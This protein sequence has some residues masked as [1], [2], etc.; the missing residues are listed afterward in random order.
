M[1]VAT[2]GRTIA[3]NMHRRAL[4]SAGTGA[5][6]SRHRGEGCP[7][8][9]GRGIQEKEVTIA[10]VLRDQAGYDT[11]LIGKWHLGHG[12]PSLLPLNHGFDTFIGHT[13]GCID[14]FTMTYGII[15][16]WYNGSQHVSENGSR[17]IDRYW[18]GRVFA[19]AAHTRTRTK[20][21]PRAGGWDD[22]GGQT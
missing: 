6:E 5:G 1:W 11:S 12:D 20:H 16:D 2:V 3:D 15:P 10:S 22:E 21:R 18:G 17:Q 14:F 4:T 13:G 7:R 8:R 9:P 19:S